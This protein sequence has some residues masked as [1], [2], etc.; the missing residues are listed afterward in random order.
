M[1]S[2]AAVNPAE[3]ARSDKR[4]LVRR[5][6]L[7][8]QDSISG[9]G[10]GGKV[11]RRTTGMGPTHSQFNT[12]RAGPFRVQI[13]R[14]SNE[15]GLYWQERTCAALARVTTMRRFVSSAAAAFAALC[16]QRLL[17]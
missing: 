13:Q 3:I 17:I 14:L 5:R 11:V 9:Y 12:L 6:R 8:M 10:S 1:R 2:V 16:K 4:N 15:A 7:L